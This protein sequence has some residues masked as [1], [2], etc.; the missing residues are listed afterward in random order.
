M[1][2]PERGRSPVRRPSG[3]NA[4][5]KK[6][7]SFTSPDRFVPARK[8]GD[9]VSTTFRVNKHPQQLSPNEKLLRRRLAGDDPFLST[10]HR[11]SGHLGQR[12]VSTRLRQSPYQRPR[13]VT[14]PSIIRGSHSNGPPRQVSAGTVWGV[15][16]T[17]AVLQG[18]SN[19]ILNDAQNQGGRGSTAPVYVAKFLPKKTRSDERMKHE[20]RIALALDIDPTARLLGTCA[21]CVDTPPSPTSP[22]YEKLSPILWEDN[23]W[24]RV[25]TEQCKW[26]SI[27]SS[28]RGFL[29]EVL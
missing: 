7:N 11:P 24:K 10:I 8:F 12:P 5:R 14:D 28:T 17:S 3:G 13:L 22:Q 16:G 6:L 9:T 21:T 29:R 25:G 1:A 15:G 23:A 4:A 20:A 27:S 26:I 19:G 18:F 2:S